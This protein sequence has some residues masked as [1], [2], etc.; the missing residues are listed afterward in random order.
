MTTD[1]V[2]AM[3]LSKMAVPLGNSCLDMHL[4]LAPSESALMD[5]AEMSDDDEERREK[6]R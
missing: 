1:S 5:V 4:R 3:V 2:V 6:A